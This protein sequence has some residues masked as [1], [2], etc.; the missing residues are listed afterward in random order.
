MKREG[1]DTTDVMTPVVFRLKPDEKWKTALI[2]GPRSAVQFTSAE[3]MR[4]FIAREHG[5]DAVDVE[6]GGQ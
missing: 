4:R 3:G 1:K 5:V 6:L 2:G